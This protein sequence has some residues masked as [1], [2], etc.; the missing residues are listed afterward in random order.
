MKGLPHTVAILPFGNETE[1]VG[2]SGQVRKS[3]SNHFSS[4]PYRKIDPSIVDEKV[5]Q[6]EKS[7]GKN[8]FEIPPS[9][10]ASALGVEGLIYGKVTDFKKVYA[11]AYSQM[12]VEAEVRLVNAKTGKEAW[13]FKDAARYH[14]GSVPLS[15]VGFVMTAVSTAVNLT[16]LQRVRVVNELGWKLNEKIPVPTE[17]KAESRP[18]IKNALS[19]AKEGP[20]GTGKVFKVAV[21]GEVGQIG[22][23]DIGGLKKGMLMK[24]VSDG[25]Y[26]GEY[27]VSPGE[28]IKEAPVVITLKR[29][30]G[31]ESV[32]LDISGLVTFD[33]AAPPAVEGLKGR[34]FSDR[35]ELS[36]NKVAAPDLTGYKV[37]KSLKPLSGYEE[38]GVVEEEKFIDKEIKAGA[39][40]YYRVAAVDAAGNESEQ[41]DAVKLTP[42]EKSPV[43]LTGEMTS[44]RT[45]PNGDYLVVGKVTVA[46]GVKLDIEPGAKLLFEKDASLKVL[47]SVSANGNREQWIEFMPKAADTVW[48]GITVEGG[49][50]VASFIK[51][52]GAVAALDFISSK[53][54]VRNAVIEGNTTGI[55]S[56]GVPSP[57][58]SSSTIWHNGVGLKLGSSQASIKSTE[59]TQ[60]KIGIESSDSSP[61][62][63]DSNIHSNV[64]NLKAGEEALTADMNYFGSSVY[65]EMRF[66]GNVKVSTVLD[67]EFPDGKPVP[68]TF[69]PYARLTPDERKA[70]AAELSI[71]A[72]KYFRERNFGRSAEQFGELLKLE[73]TP[74]AYYYIALSYQGMEENEKA[75]T[76]LKKGAERFPFDS[77]IL[78]GY[79][80]LLYQLGKNDEAKTILKE[81]VRLNAGDRQI[82]FIL[83]RLEAK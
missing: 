11:L 25:Q 30:S 40:Y 45:L 26:L 5:A 39:A 62:I 48:K 77:N 52:S 64:V 70:K 29:N 80:L 36:W 4:K 76:F 34:S 38:A 23:F 10:V 8:I 28:N 46:R 78:K 37:L 59:I 67:R 19:N 33:T 3:F 42:R 60:N 69:N 18:V 72:G 61:A 31:E 44:D 16:E 66:K 81:A 56:S 6:L 24:E 68:V 54:E 9:E 49:E 17:L 2:I 22:L 41:K 47:G 83:E 55:R 14:E 58:I 79:G 20:F 12:G 53:A 73:E 82:K 15:P 13:K 27:V 43:V 1:E 7:T 32:W 35:L 57:V 51:A 65:D 71:A 63:K 21:E 74:T 75:L 50:A